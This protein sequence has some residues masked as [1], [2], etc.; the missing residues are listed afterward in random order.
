MGL[1]KRDTI[2]WYRV[3]LHLQVFH[4]LTVDQQIHRVLGRHIFSFI[5][6]LIVGQARKQMVLKL[7]F[8]GGV[9]TLTTVQTRPVLSFV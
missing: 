6:I 1:S 4:G 3:I 8:V 7:G 2:V 5:R 9:N